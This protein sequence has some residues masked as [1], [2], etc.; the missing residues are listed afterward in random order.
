VP[1]HRIAPPTGRATGEAVP[2]A[3]LGTRNRQADSRHMGSRGPVRWNATGS[4]RHVL[5]EAA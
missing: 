5:W 1:P 4:T 2:P 3:R